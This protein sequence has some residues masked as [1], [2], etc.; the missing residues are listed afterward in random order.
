MKHS[1]LHSIAVVIAFVFSINLSAQD[2]WILSARDGFN[3]INNSTVYGMNVFNG[4]IYAAAGSDSGFV[5]RSNS[6]NIN[7]W[8]KVFSNPGSASVEAITSTPVGGGNMYISSNGSWF[9]T[10]RVYR[11]MDGVT[12]NPYFV[13]STS[14]SFIVPFKGLGVNDS[15]YLVE[16]NSNGDHILKSHY[17]NNDPWNQALSWDTVLNFEITNPYTSITA[18]GKHNTSLYIGTSSAQFYSSTDGGNWIYNATVASG[19]NN[20]NNKSITAIASFMGKIFVGTEN[21]IEGAQIWS[22]PDNGITWGIMQQYSN[23][24]DAISSL[25]VADGQLWITAR[26]Y[27][28]YSDGI[29]SKSSDG[30]TFT[31]SDSMSF[32]N[33]GNNGNHASILQFGNNIYWGGEHRTG[34]KSFNMNGAQIWRLCTVTPPIVNL[35]PDQIV[36]PGV[37]VPLDAGPGASAYIWQNMATTQ[38]TSVPAPGYWSVEY[39]GINGCSSYD[40]IFIDAL[41][42]PAVNITQPETF[43]GMPVT[44]CS[45]TSTNMSG[46]ANSNVY[47]PFPPIHKATNDSISDLLPPVNDTINVSGLLTACSCNALMSVTIDSTY[48]SYSGDLVFTIYA[49]DGSNTL[50]TGQRETNASNAYFGTEFR[51]NALD[52]ITVASPPFTG[53]YR[54]EGDFH[55]LTG[56]PNGNWSLNV[57][58]VAG[59]DAGNL[60]GWSIRFKTDDT[61]LTFSWTPATGLT[62]V[63]TLNTVATP[64]VS[65]TYTLTT[66]NSIGCSTNT[67]IGYN[68]PAISFLQSSD[69][70]CYGGY[71]KLSPLGATQTTT[72]S[73]STGLSDSIGS[74]ST[75]TPLTSIH[76]Y[77]HDT[78]FGC[79]VGDSIYIY[80]NSEMFLNSP[81]PDTICYGDVASLTASVS[82]GTAPYTY[83]WDAGGSYLYGSTISLSPISGTSFTLSAT[84]LAGC[85]V[86]G[87][88]A[89]IS[90]TPSTDIYGKVT[91]SGGDVAGSSVVLYRYQSY[92]TH[93]DTAMVTTTD[94]SG[95]YYF[96]SVNHSDYIIKVFPIASYTTLVP[97]YYGN[98]FLWDSAMVVT[99]DCAMADT[100]NI[101]CVEET[102][103]TGPASV[104]GRV[105]EDY[106]F[107]RQP[108][109]PIPG[110]DV[111]LG[112]NPGGQLVTNTQ[113]DG[114]GDYSFAGLAYGNYTIYAD[115]P[116]LGCDSSYTVDL[117]IAN[118]DM[119][120]LNYFVDSTHINITSLATGISHPAN[121]AKVNTFSV[122]PNPSAGATNIEYSVSE[123]SK[124]TLGVYNVLGVKII[125]L[126]DQEQSVG[127]YKIELN[128]EKEKQ[129]NTGVY[130]INLVINGKS[131][132]HRLVISK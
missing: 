1:F 108:G 95:N 85:P 42:A 46:T 30:I 63:N 4:S 34:G 18:I 5:Y 62:S 126:V 110:V 90:V 9:D 98:Q 67:F 114:N 117:D 3:H 29:V 82:G 109:D 131:S 27:S 38:T 22:S 2:P 122:Y 113:T 40:T 102:S 17:N 57:Q 7:S 132:I 58:D 130:F 77:V 87:G 75:T 53:A 23:T 105:L 31:T 103:F 50:L 44:V 28:A 41:P 24:Y 121:V 92:L 15:I 8:T 124:V 39:I 96:P 83:T 64:T 21:N 11:S 79:P 94:V 80:A 70:V 10:S 12:W 35:G 59:G 115:I 37:M 69:T 106:G 32:G 73:P 47:N 71:L 128:K 66:T 36:C 101:A 89:S 76:Y 33:T 112:R 68:V 78:L 97:S 84:D 91:Y 61:V 107:Q 127:V 49:P 86:Y 74:I 48:H 120:N 129:L 116:G 104:A 118:S 6:G 19:F 125:D 25:T 93:F 51:M 54:P 88:S 16:K 81:A 45:G 119:T 123:N 111:K 43:A 56:D 52:P 13:S 55:T 60:K 72:W 99:H 26:N 100:F 65:T 14:I 20:P